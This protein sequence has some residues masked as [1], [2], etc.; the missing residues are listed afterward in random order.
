MQV[1]S[2]LA[3]GTAGLPFD[4]RGP[5]STRTIN[6]QPV[7][8]KYLYNYLSPAT[9]FSPVNPLAKNGKWF[10]YRQAHLHLRFAEAANLEGFTKLAC[11][12]YNNGIPRN[13]DV[14]AI[15][16]KTNLMNTFN[17]PDPYK[18]DARNGAIPNFRSPWYR[19]DGIRFRAGLINY[20]L[21]A[22][23]VADSITQN[24]VGI[25]NEAALETAF[26]GNRWPD[27]LRFALR[28]DDPSIVA[29]KVF[30]K[31]TKDGVGNAAQV[32]DKLM[33]RDWFLPF[34]LQ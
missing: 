1:N 30:Q 18:F 6:G 10:L 17:Y 22:T 28:K 13:F 33:K 12:L 20:P 9:G 29:E 4:A 3:I 31:L 23:T 27:L 25:L 24:E 5:L 32:R 21:T 14:T 34:K 7:A 15:P 26:E 2:G 8:M 11:A 16:D 19:N